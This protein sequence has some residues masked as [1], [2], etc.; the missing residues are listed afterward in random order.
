M[1][2]AGLLAERDLLE[3]LAEQE[4]SGRRLGEV[5]VARGFVSGAA[6]AN[7]L[8]EQRGSFSRPSMGLAPAYGP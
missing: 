4:R 2:D 6:V 3:A 7:A 8:A 1:V 5:L